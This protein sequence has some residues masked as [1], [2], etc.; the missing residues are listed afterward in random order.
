MAANDVA[1]DF[2]EKKK[3]FES[4]SAEQF[5]SENLLGKFVDFPVK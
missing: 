5:K 1:T 4:D 3:S 2:T